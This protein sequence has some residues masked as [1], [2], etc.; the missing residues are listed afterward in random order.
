MNG[1]SALTIGTRLHEFEI[2][3][4][5][6]TGGY[7]IVY[8]AHDHSLSRRVAIKEY[9]PAQLAE[10]GAGRAVTVKAARLEAPFAD[11]RS[12]FL[13]EARLLARFEHASLVKVYRYWEENATAYMA[14]PL[15]AG[16]TL[17]A[18]VRDR[19]LEPREL[20]GI[21]EQLLDALA[22]LHA[23]GCIH[24]DVAPDN[25]MLLPDGRA[26]L[27]DFGAARRE[28]GADANA[29][30]KPGYSPIEQCTPQARLAEGPW[31]DLYALAAVAYFTI[32]RR[33]PQVATERIHADRMLALA[34][35]GD[36]R[37]PVAM[38]AGL[39]RALALMPCDRPKSAAELRCALGWDVSPVESLQAPRAAPR[40]PVVSLLA[41]ERWIAL[42][43]LA[44]VLALA[45]WLAQPPMGVSGTGVRGDLPAK[46]VATLSTTSCAI[47]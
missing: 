24:R 37:L 35:E 39:D 16:T 3:G 20:R 13:H 8:L 38:R 43:M 36:P 32:T 6:A 21:L 28:L 25:I 17:A 22:H 7:G 27:L 2:R 31:T 40:K 45:A 42:A 12:A 29:V 47:A 23:A 41:L 33:A 19:P 18:R 14:M 9:L 10:R 46:C 4:V 5:I 11:G 44:L 34:S 26:V 15:L 30:A 1:V